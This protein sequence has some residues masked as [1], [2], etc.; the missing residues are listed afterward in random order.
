MIV[1]LFK[2]FAVAAFFLGS[3]AVLSPTAASAQMW[4][5]APFN[6]ISWLNSYMSNLNA[7]IAAM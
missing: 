3:T 7:Q 5:Y 6:Q 1:D 2:R 4:S